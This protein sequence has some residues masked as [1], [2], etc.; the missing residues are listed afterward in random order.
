MTNAYFSQV[1]F[2][3][4]NPDCSGSTILSW[5]DDLL[6]V[7]QYDWDVFEYSNGTLLQHFE[8][9]KNFSSRLSLRAGSQLNL[10][11]KVTLTVPDLD[12]PVYA[13]YIIDM[14]LIGFFTMDI[15]LRFLSCPSRS[16][17]FCS[18]INVFDLLALVGTYACLIVVSIEKQYRYIE[19]PWLRLLNF[20]LVFRALRLFRIVKNV[21]ASKVLAYSLTQNV[22]DMSL[23]VLLLFIGISAF[24]CL[25]YFSETRDTVP[26]IPVAWYWAIVT[27]T[28]VG[29]GD[30]SPSTELGRALASICAICGVL[31]LAVTLPMFVNNFLSLYQYSCVNESIEK[32]K[33]KT[34]TGNNSVSP[35]KP[36]S[37]GCSD[38]VAVP[39]SRIF[40]V[41]PMAKEKEI[42]Y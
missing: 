21:R 16:R 5:E 34:E 28:T 29:Y 20:L 35:G 18:P 14:I 31:L 40:V 6:E 26:S 41:K 38:S 25:F 36:E 33:G 3:L 39:D 37:L 7:D 17:Y 9:P 23:L 12:V 13:F 30:I 11:K 2:V 27:M 22:K 32:K 1:K 10:P 4:G 15:T 24:A 42:L 8:Y 19:T